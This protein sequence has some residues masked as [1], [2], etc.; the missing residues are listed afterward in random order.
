[1]TWTITFRRNCFTTLFARLRATRPHGEPW[2]ILI[3]IWMLWKKCV[4]YFY[5]LL[6]ALRTVEDVEEFFSTHGDLFVMPPGFI[7]ILKQ[8]LEEGDLDNHISPRLFYHI[9]RAAASNTGVGRAL[10][11]L[12]PYLQAK[13]EVRF[14]LLLVTGCFTW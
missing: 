7:N 2:Y 9:V 8:L 5:S 4:F 14:L 10:A 6:G 13:A 12:L 1:M 3:H 11:Y